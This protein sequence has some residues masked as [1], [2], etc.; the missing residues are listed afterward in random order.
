MAKYNTS[1]THCNL[2]SRH[3][4]Y[5][6]G[7]I[8][9]RQVAPMLVEPV[10]APAFKLLVPGP[11]HLPTSLLIDPEFERGAIVGYG[12]ADLEVEFSDLP[13]ISPA[14]VA[15]WVYKSFDWD[16]CHGESRAWL[17]GYLLGALSSLAEN[18]RALA[19]V[20]IAHLSFILALVPSL[21][22]PSLYRALSDAGFCH[23]QSVRA[24]RSN[25]RAHK[26][27]GCDLPMAQRFALADYAHLDTPYADGSRSSAYQL[28]EESEVA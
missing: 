25:V 7:L 17:V 1:F 15:N 24:Y 6:L 20:G 18:D 26:E 12:V 23:D 5:R 16:V 28:D 2:S 9:P 19:L 13:V 21:P 14:H 8:D 10:D 4:S 27:A 3:A 11:E 22:E